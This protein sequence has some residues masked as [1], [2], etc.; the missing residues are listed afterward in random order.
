MK[1]RIIAAVGDLFFAA[2]IRGTAEQAGAEASFPKSADALLTSAREEPPALFVFDLQAQNFDV[3]EL[4]RTLKADERLRGVPLVGFFS[5]VET[6]LQRR[7]QE[8]GFDAVMP[9]SLFTRRLPEI[10][11]GEI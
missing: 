5:H 2:R 6:E 10:L 4:A 11:R 1:R 9:R 3:C 7:A 8:A